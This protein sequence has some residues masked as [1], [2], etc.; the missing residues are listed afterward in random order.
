MLSL[1]FPDLPIILKSGRLSLA[2]EAEKGN[3]K[4][5]LILE[6]RIKIKMA[7]HGQRTEPSTWLFKG[8]PRRA[9]TAE[10]RW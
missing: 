5:T 4:R 1:I 9:A 10:K 6:T 3:I 7:Q 8:G 2:S